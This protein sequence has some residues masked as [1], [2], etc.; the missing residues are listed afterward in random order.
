MIKYVFPYELIDD[1]SPPRHFADR[2]PSLWRAVIT[3][4]LMDASSNSHK[5]ENLKH[6]REALEWLKGDSDD[7]L[8]VCEHAGLCPHYVREQAALAIARGCNWRLPA[9]LGWRA[10]AQLHAQ[11]LQATPMLEEVE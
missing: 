2:E 7:F 8:T 1:P 9:G 5:A 3:Q 11:L 4:A 10:Q 6:K